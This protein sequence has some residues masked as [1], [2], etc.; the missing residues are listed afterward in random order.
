MTIHSAAG[1]SR[2][3]TPDGRSVVNPGGGSGGGSGDKTTIALLLATEPRFEAW[4]EKR[5]SGEG[6]DL[7]N[8]AIVRALRA[9]S[10]APCSLAH[11]RALA[12]LL[13]RQALTDRLR[14]VYRERDTLAELREIALTFVDDDPQWAT[15]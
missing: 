9:R 4:L 3:T 10:L 12:W 13:C 14:K 15:Q 8:D 5:R 6:S 11:A 7:L 1:G 2:R